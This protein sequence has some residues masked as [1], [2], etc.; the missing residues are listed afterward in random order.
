MRC[1]FCQRAILPGQEQRKRVQFHRQD[2]GTVKV[3][4]VNMPDG[5]LD[6]ATGR[7]E[8]LA[9]SRCYWADKKRP[10]RQAADTRGRAT[11]EERAPSEGDAGHRR[12]GAH[13]S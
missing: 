9:H 1:R 12:D 7:V 5:P 3:F 10:L 2:D 13:S 11:A 4:G 8:F 6:S